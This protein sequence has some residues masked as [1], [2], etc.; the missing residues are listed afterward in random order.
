[1]GAMEA[2]EHSGLPVVAACCQ[3]KALAFSGANGLDSPEKPPPISFAPPV[4]PVWTDLSGQPRHVA[5][6]RQ[7]IPDQSRRHLELS[8]LLN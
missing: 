2:P 1:M 4:L 3:T 8:V 7:F 6:Q 5:I